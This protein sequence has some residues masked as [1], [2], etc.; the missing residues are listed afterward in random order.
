M[1]YFSKVCFNQHQIRITVHWVENTLKFSKCLHLIY[2]MI[3]LNF[4]SSAFTLEVLF[5]QNRIYK[6]LLLFRYEP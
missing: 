3:A 4:K 6:T 5:V 2:D 1:G